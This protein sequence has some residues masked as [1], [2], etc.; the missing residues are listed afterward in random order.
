MVFKAANKQPVR[1]LNREIS[2][3]KRFAVRVGDFERCDPKTSYLKNLFLFG[4]FTINYETGHE[5]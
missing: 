1:I 5:E 3:Q 2:F 4:Y